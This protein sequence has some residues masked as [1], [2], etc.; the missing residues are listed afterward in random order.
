MSAE[1]GSVEAGRSQRCGRP[2]FYASSRTSVPRRRVRK[3]SAPAV[4]ADARASDSPAGG[5]VA[6]HL[7]GAVAPCGIPAEHHCPR[8]CV[9]RRSV[10]DHGTGTRGPMAPA[11]A[12]VPDRGSH[13]GRLRT[14]ARATGRRGRTRRHPGRR[15]E[16][17]GR[18]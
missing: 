9:A 17:R 18:A 15:V 14:D 12:T 7:R 2:A 10:P 13:C 11:G 5:R 3:E 8:G 6:L 16:L 1:I 4:R